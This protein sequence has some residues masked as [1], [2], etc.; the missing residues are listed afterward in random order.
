MLIIQMNPLEVLCNVA[1][2]VCNVNL[3]FIYITKFSDYRR[4]L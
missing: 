3:D 1:H 4:L 2:S